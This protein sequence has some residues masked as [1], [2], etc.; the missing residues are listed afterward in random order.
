MAKHLGSN[1][2]N[3]PLR[4]KRISFETERKTPCTDEFLRIYLYL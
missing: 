4:L 3:P 2:Y 1:F